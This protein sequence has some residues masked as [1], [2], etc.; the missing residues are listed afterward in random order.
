MSL[1]NKKIVL[2]IECAELIADLRKLYSQ[3]SAPSASKA[4]KKGVGDFFSTWMQRRDKIEPVH[5]EFLDGVQNLVGKLAEN[6]ESLCE[7]DSQACREFSERALAIIF[8]PKPKTERTDIQRF[9]A[10]SEYYAPPLFPYASR[11]E[12][13]RIR[14]GLLE[15]VP[16]RLMY[17]KHRELVDLLEEMS[18]A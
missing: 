16:R 1:E 2:N 18:K 7:L 14:A 15:R 6:F 11:E 9:L 13:G 17:P 5:Q 10:I 3:Y 4:P 8:A 12:L